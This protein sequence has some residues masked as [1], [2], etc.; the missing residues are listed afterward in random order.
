MHL[1][2]GVTGIENRQQ[3]SGINKVATVKPLSSC[4]KDDYLTTDCTSKHFFKNVAYTIKFSGM[5]L[6]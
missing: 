6:R 5:A 4:Y 3:D 1:L 2:Q